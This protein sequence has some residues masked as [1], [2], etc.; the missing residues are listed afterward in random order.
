LGSGG[1]MLWGIFWMKA[2]LL[3]V[4]VQDSWQVYSL[5]FGEYLLWPL[6][7]ITKSGTI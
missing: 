5:L 3:S 6:L 4:L 2:L 1:L 7:E